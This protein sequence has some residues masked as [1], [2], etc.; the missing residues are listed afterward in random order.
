MNRPFLAILIELKNQIL[1]IRLDQIQLF[2]THGET[3]LAAAAVAVVAVLDGLGVV[4]A[5][6]VGLP[7]P[8]PEAVVAVAG[9]TG[10][11]VGRKRN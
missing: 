7:L 4:G 10:I 6:L 9:A 11:K 5:V 8:P 1:I 2:K 3:A